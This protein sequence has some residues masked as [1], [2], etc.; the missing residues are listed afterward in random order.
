[1]PLLALEVSNQ[2]KHIC[3]GS[4]FWEGAEIGALCKSLPHFHGSVLPDAAQGPAWH[5]P[6]LLIHYT[7]CIVFK[8]HFW[9]LS[10]GTAKYKVLWQ[11]SS[12]TKDLKGEEK[13]QWM[14]SEPDKAGVPNQY[15]FS[16]GAG[17]IS[18]D[19]AGLG[20]TINYLLPAQHLPTV[21]PLPCWEN[22]VMC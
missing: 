5:Q 4:F 21:Y 7:T 19:S 8:N 22:T 11:I 20:N 2:S 3:Q 12:E 6:A 14:C 18:T 10:K 1:M 13:K 9:P 17:L 15:C 16:Y